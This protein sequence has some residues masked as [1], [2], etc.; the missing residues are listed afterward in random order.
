MVEGITYFD[1]PRNPRYPARWHVREDGWMG[2]SFCMQE[3]FD[4]PAGAPLTLRY[5]L[6]SH[7]GSYDQAKAEAIHTAFSRRPRFLI[8]KSTEKHRQYEVVREST[9]R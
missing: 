4:I 2:A 7:R 1:H 6:Y 3:G 8:R 5:L 9:S